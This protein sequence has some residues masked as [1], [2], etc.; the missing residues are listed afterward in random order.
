[1]ATMTTAQKA[2]RAVRHGLEVVGSP[3]NSWPEVMRKLHRIE[4]TAHRWAEDECNYD[5]SEAESER[6]DKAI[7]DRVD[8]I[9]RFRAQ[10]IPVIYD[11]DPRGYALK[12]DDAWMREHRDITEGMVT[13]WGGYGILAPDF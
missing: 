2:D 6:R 3:V 11:G 12:I 4:A 13:D 8:R 7:L 1:M 9:L 10:S 5:I